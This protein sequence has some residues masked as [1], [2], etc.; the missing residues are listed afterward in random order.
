[1]AQL[2]YTRSG[3]ENEHLAEYLLSKIAFL[4]QPVT[5]S[6]DLG[7]DYFCTLFEEAVL[8]KAPQL[9]PRNSFAIQIKTGPPEDWEM[10]KKIEYLNR[11]EIPYFIGFVEQ[12]TL[13]LSIYS[14]RYLPLFFSSVGVRQKLTLKCVASVSPEEMYNQLQRFPLDNTQGDWISFPLV[15]ELKG[16]SSRFEIDEI[17]KKISSLCAMTQKD[18]ASKMNEEHVY[19]LSENII[20]YVAGPGSANVFRRTLCLRLGEA[21]ANLKFIRDNAP[22]YFYSQEFEVLERCYLDLDRLGVPGAN[23]AKICYDH[24]KRDLTN[25]RPLGM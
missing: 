19:S 3:F 21:F 5:V 18:I 4:S 22:Q 2:K 8:N 23:L 11:L 14:G 16:T 15:G 17:S 10:D 6:D 7:T 9:F 13:S 20:Y 25:G 24:L 12:A 1:M